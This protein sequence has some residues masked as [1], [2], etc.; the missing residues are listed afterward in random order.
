MAACIELGILYVQTS[1]Y[2]FMDT[3]SLASYHDGTVKHWS[4]LERREVR[5]SIEKN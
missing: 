1:M 3:V 2:L 4:Y 5:D